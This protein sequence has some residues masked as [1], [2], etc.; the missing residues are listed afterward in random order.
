MEEN[1]LKIKVFNEIIEKN[2]E[3]ELAD[4]II[5]SSSFI[6]QILI[7]I[8]KENIDKE[9]LVKNITSLKDYLTTSIFEYKTK[10]KIA[11]LLEIKKKENE[12]LKKYENQKEQ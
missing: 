2:L 10:L 1:S 3:K 12:E 8:A 7:D 9:E 5:K 4:T 6:N 11:S